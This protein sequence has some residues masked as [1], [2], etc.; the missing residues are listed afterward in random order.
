MQL[1]K[2]QTATLPEPLLDRREAVP[3]L[4]GDF[5][6]FLAVAG[7]AGAAQELIYLSQ[8]SPSVFGLVGAMGAALPMAIGLALAQPKR[9]VLCHTGD[10]ELLMTLG[11]LAT[12]AVMNPPNLRIVVVDN[13]RFGETGNQQ[14]HTG[15][16]TRIDTIAVGCGIAAVLVVNTE[17]DIPAARTLLHDGNGLCFILLRVK[18]GPALKLRRDLRAHPERDRFRRSLLG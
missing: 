18:E 13:G 6:D 14:S 12:A 16:G 7:L 5:S 2:M 4:L 3:A 15:L 1:L 17:D 8:E 10:A 11:A 9:R